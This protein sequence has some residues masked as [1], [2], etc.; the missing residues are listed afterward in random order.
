MSGCRGGSSELGFLIVDKLGIA[1][2]VIKGIALLVGFVGTFVCLMAA[3]GLAVHN[4]WLRA[5]LAIV[6]AIVL[7]A[8][9]ADRL[10]P[11]DSKEEKA[12][13]LTSD[14]FALF[15]IAVPLGFAVVANG[16]TKPWL[17]QEGDRLTTADQNLLAAAA[18][19]LAGVDAHAATGPDP[20][21]ST[22]ASAS[23]SAVAGGT[24]SAGPAPSA[25]PTASTT[26]TPEVKK[27][28]PEEGELT[29]AELFKKWAPSVVTVSVKNA[30]GGGGGTGFLIDNKGTIATNHHVIDGAT[31]ASIKFKNGAMYDKV[32]ILTEDPQA[33]LALLRVELDSPTDG[34]APS[35][36]EVVLGDSDKI[37][38]GERA[39]SIGNPLGL[40][41]T[42]TTGVISSRRTYRGKQWIQMSTPVSPGNSGGPVFNGLGEVVGVTTAIVGFG[43]AQNLNLA[44]PINVLKTKVKGDYPG[45]RKF[46]KAGSSS[47]W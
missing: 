9:V 7:P 6:V 47:N 31:E 29:P 42:L 20:A 40:E 3:A 32:W 41:H 11:D 21:G 25:A 36:T 37:E 2:K 1:R 33:D 4:G 34:D 35:A 14:V 46:G 30:R 27:K 8:V 5:I 38:V 23:G 16:F 13:G 12:K 28:P 10:L 39:I 45:K 19:M 18:Y 15:W 43:M 26:A 44:V 17:T 22:S 24:A